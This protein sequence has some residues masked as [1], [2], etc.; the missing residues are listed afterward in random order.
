MHM[1]K[2]ILL[3]AAFWMAGFAV[4]AADLTTKAPAATLI[5][6]GYPYSSSGLFFGF[7]SEG[8]AGTFNGADVPGVNPSSATTTD[9]QIGATIGYAWGTKNSQ[10]AYTGEADFGFTNFNG[11]N[12]GIALSGPLSFEQRFVAWVP[13][14]VLTSLLPNA[15]SFFGTV[16]PFQPVQSGLTVSNLQSGI[17]IGIRERDISNSF[18]GLQ[19]NKVWLVEPV[20]KLFAME[21]VSNGVALRAW[22]GVALPSDG[23][24]LGPVPGMSVKLGPEYLAGVGAYF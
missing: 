20:I 21:Q 12:A 1:K 10:I 7:Y 2:M 3:A 16:P 18:Q 23:K 17:G 6:N 19:A 24:V 15:S 14:S 11:S 8:G 9:A 13:T 22:A 4:Q 5:S